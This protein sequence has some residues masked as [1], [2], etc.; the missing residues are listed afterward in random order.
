MKLI[1]RFMR[2]VAPA[3]EK[4]RQEFRLELARVNAHTDDLMKTL[5]ISPEKMKEI[6]RP[7]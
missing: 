1:H 7:K 5:R 3:C 4:Q 2:F 6:Q